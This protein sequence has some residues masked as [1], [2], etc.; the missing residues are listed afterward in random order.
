ML[1]LAAVRL[2]RRPKT[3][4]PAVTRSSETPG[5]G[6]FPPARRCQRASGAEP[7][8]W[9]TSIAAKASATSPTSAACSPSASPIASSCSARSAYRRIDADL[10]PVARNGQPQDYLINQGWS[11]GLGDAVARREVQLSI[12]AR[13]TA[14][15]RRARV[16]PRFPTASADDGLGTGKMDFQFDLIGSRE[17]SEKVELTTVDRLQVPRQSRWLQPDAGLQVG[18]RR[19]VTQ[20]A[21]ASVDRRNVRRSAVRSGPAFTG[22]NPAP[23]MPSQ[24]DPDAT[25]DSSAASSFDRP[26]A[27]S[28]APAWPTPRC[29]TCTAATSSPR[30]TATSIALACRSA[31]A[32]TRRAS[33]RP[34]HRAA[35]RA[36]R[37][38]RRRRTAR[39]R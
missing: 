29:I 27:S 10:V 20:A 17:F 37:S 14:A 12:A 13:A 34:R 24:W 22:S 28:S 5:S 8:A 6:S 19:R 36:D 9:S 2:R 4:G 32:T 16:W 26:A 23:G 38:R 33:R 21:R 31:S 15:I 11:T 30:K 3:A 7:S 18:H 1:S 35:D 39:P 25:R